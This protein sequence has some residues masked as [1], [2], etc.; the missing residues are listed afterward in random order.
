MLPLITTTNTKSTIKLFDRPCVAEMHHLLPHIQYLVSIN[1]Q[2]ASMSFNGCHLRHEHFHLSDC[3]SAVI[4]LMTTKCNGIL[5]EHS[6]STAIP[7][8]ST[9]DVVDQ[10][11]KT[12]SITFRAALI[13]NTFG[14]Y[15][16][17]GEHQILYTFIYITAIS[18]NK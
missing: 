3:P 6:T 9:S 8:T 13:C 12:G 1:I 15:M 18:Y 16:V 5:V 7:P 17:L 2:K 11:N 4:C 10:H 14:F